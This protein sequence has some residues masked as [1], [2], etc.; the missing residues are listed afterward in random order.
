M[1][2]GQI[3][4]MGPIRDVYRNPRHPYTEALIKAFPKVNEPRRRLYAI[5]GTPPDLLN[6][7]PGC[8]FHPR[9]PLTQPICREKMPEP[10]EV[11][12]GHYAMCHLVREGVI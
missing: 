10:Y 11:G 5:P 8:R 9:C 6:P 3:V 4:E 7:P 1:Y 2:A 12:D